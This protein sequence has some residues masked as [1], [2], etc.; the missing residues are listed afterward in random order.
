MGRQ[1][2]PDA[3][4]PLALDAIA[5]EAQT[6]DG[7]K[8]ELSTTEVCAV[9]LQSE[10][11]LGKS[12]TFVL[13]RCGHKCICKPCLRKI[14]ARRKQVEI[15]CPLCRVRSKPMLLDRHDGDV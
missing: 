5:A 14:K 2:Q 3:M 7:P 12:F 9:C 6:Q 15:E 13:E 10:A 11:E 8:A 4:G 1:R